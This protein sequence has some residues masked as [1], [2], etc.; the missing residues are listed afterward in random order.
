MKNEEIIKVS[1][2]F[3]LTTFLLFGIGHV[4]PVSAETSV[5]VELSRKITVVDAPVTV[6][7]N[8]GLDDYHWKVLEAPEN[9]E[10][11]FLNPEEKV[12]SISPDKPGEYIVELTS[13]NYNENLTFTAEP[14]SDLI[15]KYAP[16]LHFHQADEYR[17][18]RVEALVRNS[19]LKKGEETT[20]KNPTLFDLENKNSTHYIELKGEESSYPKY[21]E[22]FPPTVYANLNQN[23]EYRNEEYI[24]ITYWFI[25][26]YDPKHGFASFGSHQ[27]D[28]ESTIILLDQENKE[29]KYIGSAAHGGITIA[30]FEKFSN[31]NHLDLYPE[32]GSHG[33]FLRDTTKY[34]GDGIQ[35]YSFWSDSDAECGSIKRTLSAFH[36]GRTGSADKWAP[37]DY[38]LIELTGNEIWSTYEGGLAANPGSITPPHQRSQYKDQGPHM[39]ERGCL[40]YE[41]VQGR[42]SLD[43][44]SV[45]GNSGT[46]D[47]TVTNEGGKPHEFWI[48]IETVDGDILGKENIRV[49][50]DSP[51]VLTL[52][53][54]GGSK[55]R[56]TEVGFDAEVKKDEVLRAELWLHPPET[57]CDN[58]FE[59]ESD[60]FT[61]K[62]DFDASPWWKFW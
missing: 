12:T 40:D 7:A 59:D 5:E 25:Y 8:N 62:D 30:P 58:D 24:G 11:E 17:P 23:T 2:L 39:E 38:Q 51:F 32:F 6:K 33:T 36:S 19:I 18:T 50:T 37:S 21:Q 27:G 61:I 55:S 42:I 44:C 1:I 28:V 34:D 29:P 14:Q 3:F 22:S 31:D 15:K 52:G 46:V 13:E 9:S 56:N 45:D 26:T 20:E 57:R 41:Q 54:T 49:G 48:T 35:V 4:T 16:L 10:A 47:V 60:S 43:G 53:L